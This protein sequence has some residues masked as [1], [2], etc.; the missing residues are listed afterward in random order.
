MERR[1]GNC[2]GHDELCTPAI[3][4]YLGATTIV[5]T[6]SNAAGNTS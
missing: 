1:F 3:P 6:A 4:L 5:V 2:H